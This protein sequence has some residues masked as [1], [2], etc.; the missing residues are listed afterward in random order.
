MIVTTRRVTLA[1]ARSRH[2]AAETEHLTALL[3]CQ[4]YIRPVDI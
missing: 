2:A 1:A 3:V 4:C